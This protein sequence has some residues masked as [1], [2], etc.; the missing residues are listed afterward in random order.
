MYIHYKKCEQDI[1]ARNDIAYAAGG[2][3]VALPGQG[4]EL[5]VGGQV[6]E[7]IFAH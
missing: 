6:R 4:R 1:D 7:W 3:R 2:L 5:F